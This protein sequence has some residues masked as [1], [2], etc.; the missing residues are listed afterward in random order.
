M[1]E[2]VRFKGR[3]VGVALSKAVENEGRCFRH[4]E[5]L[6]RAIQVPEWPAPNRR[7]RVPPVTEASQN[8]AC[9]VH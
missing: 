3:N 9:K 4:L 6:R 2:L 8:S 7:T 1:A 5:G